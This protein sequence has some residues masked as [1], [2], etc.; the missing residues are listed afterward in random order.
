MT[1]KDLE[2]QLQI[3]RATIRFYEK[4]GLI[5]PERLDNGYREYSEEDIKIIKQMALCIIVLLLLFKVNI[6]VLAVILH[7]KQP[8]KCIIFPKK[9]WKAA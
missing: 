5:T 9:F 6:S 1:I 7:M 8:R 2:K 3:P 4:E